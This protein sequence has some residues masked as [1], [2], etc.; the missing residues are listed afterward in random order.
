MIPQERMPL[1]QSGQQGGDGQQTS[2]CD[3]L[4]GCWT[5]SR[6]EQRIVSELIEITSYGSKELTMGSI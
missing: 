3:S 5:T 6:Q 4:E 1:A 2:P